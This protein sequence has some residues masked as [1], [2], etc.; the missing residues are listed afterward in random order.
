MVLCV[1]YL[2]LFFLLSIV[3][4]PTSMWRKEQRCFG[5]L[6]R[7]IEMCGQ[8]S[9]RFSFLLGLDLLGREI[10][11]H[12]IF[13]FGCHHENLVGNWRK[14]LLAENWKCCTETRSVPTCSGGESTTHGTV[15]SRFARQAVFLCFGFLEKIAWWNFGPLSRLRR[16]I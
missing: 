9:G 16:E 2:T 5:M 10:S 3:I 8:T 1:L 6:G 4:V 7:W 13:W 11:N 12:Y 14:T 15:N